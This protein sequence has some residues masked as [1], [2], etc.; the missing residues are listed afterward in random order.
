MIKNKPTSK[1]LIFLFPFRLSLDREIDVPTKRAL[2]DSATTNQKST[3]EATR[4][5]FRKKRKGQNSEG[6]AGS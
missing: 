6:I 5:A 1:F 2:T 4:S 3:P